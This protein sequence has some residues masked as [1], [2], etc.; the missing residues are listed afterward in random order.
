MSDLP[1]PYKGLNWQEVLACFSQELYASKFRAEGDVLRLIH[2]FAD[3][4]AE[5]NSAEKLYT[6]A[7][8]A[9]DSTSVY[10]QGLLRLGKDP[11]PGKSTV[12]LTEAR[13][14][15][16]SFQAE[17]DRLT[18]GQFRI[19]NVPV[20]GIADIASV[21]DVI[22]RAFTWFKERKDKQRN[23]LADLLVTCMWRQWYDLSAPVANAAGAPG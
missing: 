19:T 22:F 8:A 12:T 2:L 7:A 14:R 21:F 5:V 17:V 6:D 1:A 20:P 15:F 4:P 11:D 23:A 13:D 10:L 3:R 9:Y 18:I 16:S